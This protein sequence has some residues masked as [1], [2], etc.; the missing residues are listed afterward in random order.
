VELAKIIYKPWMLALLLVL[1]SLSSVVGAN[2]KGEQLRRTMAEIALLNSQ[3]TQ[4]K[5]DAT[6]IREALSARLE[7][8]KSEALQVL[9]ENK[10]TTP[11]DALEN[12]R[13]FYNLLLMAEIEAYVGRYT[14]KIGYYRV[15]CD[16]LSYLYQQADDDLKIVNTLSDLKID[17]LV[18]QT[19]KILDS[20]LA[21]AQTLVIDPATLVTK[22]PDNVLALLKWGK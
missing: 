17:A 11:A 15:A 6:G 3:M 2:E 20:Y 8:I 22:P 12:P 21:E 14:Q 4:R 16:R 9:R 10:I 7:E 5:A 19:E 13:V 18:A 1:M